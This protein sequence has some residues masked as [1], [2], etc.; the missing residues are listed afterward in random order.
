MPTE[1]APKVLLFDRS[2][3]GARADLPRLGYTVPTSQRTEAI[4]HHT[5]IV[6]SD[7]TKNVWETLDEVK[8]KM[9]Q[10]QT[11][12]P[13]LGL[14]VP[15][16][17]VG[18]LMADGTLI[19]CEGRGLHRTGAHTYDHNTSGIALSMQGNFQLATDL[20]PYL[21]LISL[22]WGW[23]KAACPN[24]GSKRPKRA[25][26]YGHRDLAPKAEPTACPGQVLYAALP[27]LTF[28]VAEEDEMTDDE[29]LAAMR[30]ILLDP[31][32]AATLGIDNTVIGRTPTKQFI[33]DGDASVRGA[34]A[35]HAKHGTGAG[36]GLKRGDTVKLT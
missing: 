21:P 30:R 13:D 3:W 18:F 17:F 12:R 6:D 29:I 10:L 23:A 26:V 20:T 4:V 9:Q 16:N 19:V 5:V 7:A 22:F 32:K 25:P 33:Q 2:D 24:L 34:L 15:Y 36:D 1:I 28:A 35:E 31:A 27:Q 14:D 11:I 8:A